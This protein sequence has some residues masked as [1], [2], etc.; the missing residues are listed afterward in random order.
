MKF[1]PLMACLFVSF[2]GI[3][4]SNSLSTVLSKRTSDQL[5]RSLIQMEAKGSI[6]KDR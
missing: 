2:L 1:E 5:S 4:I 6:L 3:R